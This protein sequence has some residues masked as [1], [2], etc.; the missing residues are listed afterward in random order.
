MVLK[1]EQQT[2]IINQIF[3]PPCVFT[4]VKNIVV[5]VLVTFR[6]NHSCIYYFLLFKNKII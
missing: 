3:S 2:E 5:I 6:M 1:C 4:D